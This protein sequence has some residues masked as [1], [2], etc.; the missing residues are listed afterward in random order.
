V[1]L[2]KDAPVKP[3]Q[4]EQREVAAKDNARDKP[5]HDEYEGVATDIEV[6]GEFNP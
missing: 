5:G 2:G 6:K 3:G 4:G 1:G